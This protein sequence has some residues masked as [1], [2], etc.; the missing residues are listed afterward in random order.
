[1]VVL[2]A[3]TRPGGCA[4]DYWRKG[5]LLPAGA[6]LLSGFEPGGLHHQMYTHL[7]LPIRARALSRVMDVLLPDDALT[8][9]TNRVSWDAEW[10]R[11]FPTA[12]RPKGRFWRRVQRLAD[13]AYQLAQGWPSLPPRTLDEL[14]RLASLARPSL[15][16]ALPAL[17]RTIADELRRAG[18]D[19]DPRHRRFL[20]AQLLISMQCEAEAAVA[21]NG[22]LAL[23][24][25][26]FGCFHV[27]GGAAGIA[28][29]LVDSV[30]ASGGRVL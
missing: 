17:W 4:G 23:E 18:A 2:E 21:L 3:H 27:P 19:A 30:R 8:I 20:D 28:A 12:E 5:V 13:Q 7:G 15:V 1:V 11:A 14:G 9:P 24:L 25:Y 22:A 6:T 16:T 29:D 10:R 26:R